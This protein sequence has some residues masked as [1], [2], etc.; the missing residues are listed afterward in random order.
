MKQPNQLNIWSWEREK[1][2]RF[3]NENP[4]C[5]VLFIFNDQSFHF[6]LVAIL[7]FILH[8]IYR[9]N[10]LP[11]SVSRC[12]SLVSLFC[13]FFIIPNQQFTTFRVFLRCFVVC[14]IIFSWRSSPMWRQL[15]FGFFLSLS[16]VMFVYVTKVLPQSRKQFL[17]KK[18]LRVRVC[19]CVL[20]CCLISVFNTLFINNIYSKRDSN[21]RGVSIFKC[22]LH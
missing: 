10:L 11:V 16:R 13:F 15:F 21:K 6:G 18:C 14:F 5:F 3:P 9:F 19:V 2:V 20:F 1:F 12:D 4:F 8:F 7:Y 17:K 22:T